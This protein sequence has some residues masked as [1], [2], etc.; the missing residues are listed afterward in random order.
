MPLE[1][2]ACLGTVKAQPLSFMWLAFGPGWDLPGAGA[3]LR[4]ESLDDPTNRLIG[5]FHGG[6]EIPCTSETMTV[7]EELATK[8]QISG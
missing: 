3:P 1:L 4:Q 6:P 2:L 5:P 7:A 8:R